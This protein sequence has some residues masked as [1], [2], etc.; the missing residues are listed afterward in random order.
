M[1]LSRAALDRIARL[2]ELFLA[3]DRGERA[4]GDYW[5]D[6]GDLQAY[7]E[8]LAA[9]SHQSALGARNVRCASPT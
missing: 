8:V 4:L 1:P 6:A 7:D 5:R 2:R 9:P 3:A